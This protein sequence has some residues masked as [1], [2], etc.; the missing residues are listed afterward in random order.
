ML[1]AITDANKSRCISWGLLCIPLLRQNCLTK[2]QIDNFSQ[3]LVG[4]STVSTI[5]NVYSL[6]KWSLL[7]AFL[8]G[9]HRATFPA[10]LEWPSLLA[11]P[12]SVIKAKLL[13]SEKMSHPYHTLVGKAPEGYS[14]STSATIA[15]SNFN[16]LVGQSGKL[17]GKI[18]KIKTFCTLLI[19]AKIFKSFI[20]SQLP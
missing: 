2:F 20:R 10:Q 16:N 11:C 1:E 12:R 19:R 4:T 3:L 17:T 5:P 14:H 8:E 15:S 6:E 13:N 9:F 7:A 18:E